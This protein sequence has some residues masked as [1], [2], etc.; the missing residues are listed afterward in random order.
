M[1]WFVIPYTG[2][3]CLAQIMVNVLQESVAGKA[4]SVW[5]ASATMVKRGARKKV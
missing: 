5:R 3:A 4:E 1:A 2:D